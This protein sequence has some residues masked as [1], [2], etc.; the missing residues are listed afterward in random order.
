MKRTSDKV[1]EEWNWV[2]R[3]CPIGWLHGN[4]ERELF[5]L[6]KMDKEALIKKLTDFEEG[7]S[8]GKAPSRCNLPGHALVVRST[9]RWNATTQTWEEVDN[10]FA[11]CVLLDRKLERYE[12]ETSR[13]QKERKKDVKL[14]RIIFKESRTRTPPEGVSP[15]MRT[16]LYDGWVPRTRLYSIS[17]IH[18]AQAMMRSEFASDMQFQRAVDALVEVGILKVTSRRIEHA[19]S[20]KGRA[21]WMTFYRLILGTYEEGWSPEPWELLTPMILL[22]R[23]RAALCKEVLYWAGKDV[24]DS[25]SAMMAVAS[26]PEIRDHVEGR[27]IEIFGAELLEKERNEMLIQRVD[28]NQAR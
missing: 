6:F 14:A 7:K 27:L 1:E 25:Y 5:E 16:M 2:K 18:E 11:R 20:K 21:R 13:G 19:R 10:A 12:S 22:K 23:T 15:T 8:P 3:L 4:G 26:S 9:D 28:N 24:V 17:R